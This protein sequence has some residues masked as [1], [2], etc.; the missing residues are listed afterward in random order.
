MVSKLSVTSIFNIRKYLKLKVFKLDLKNFCD[1]LAFKVWQCY[2]L[3]KI[4]Q[5]H[6]TNESMWIND[7]V[8]CRN[9]KHCSSYSVFIWC[10]PLN[11]SGW[12]H[13]IPS[14]IACDLSC[15]LLDLGYPSSSNQ[16]SLSSPLASSRSFSVILA[17]S[18][19]S[20]QD[21]EQP[22]NHYRHPSSAHV[23]TI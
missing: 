9:F 16:S 10:C 22:S 18:C 8:L 20:L 5:A 15:S 4:I 6:K 7:S 12:I 23:H 19:H 21:L 2:T 17:S 11:R 13:L 3:H 14:E 1:V